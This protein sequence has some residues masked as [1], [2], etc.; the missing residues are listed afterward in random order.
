MRQ[1]ARPS[2]TFDKELD[3]DERACRH[4]EDEPLLALIFEQIGELRVY[5]LRPGNLIWTDA[6]GVV[7]GT[8]SLISNISNAYVRPR[9]PAP[10]S[11]PEGW[12]A[13]RRASIYGID[14]G[15]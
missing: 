8:R 9:V 13:S 3:M 11:G 2:E 5:R 4:L 10:A 7:S 1:Y 14:S 6:S 12:Q 15:S